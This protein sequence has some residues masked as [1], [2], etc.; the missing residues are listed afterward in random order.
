MAP[1]LR[2]GMQNN[3]GQIKPVVFAA[4][5]RPARQFWCLRKKVKESGVNACNL[6]D[7]SILKKN[8]DF[9]HFL[10]GKWA[11]FWSDCCVGA[12]W[13]AQVGIHPLT[14]AVLL[15]CSTHRPNEDTFK[16]L[17]SQK[18]NRPAGMKRELQGVINSFFFF[19]NRCIAFEE[20]SLHL[21]LFTGS[22]SFLPSWCR[23]SASKASV[24]R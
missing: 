20:R 18:R 1:S 13:V 5:W 7:V 9:S 8:S 4:I 15:P 21:F 17:S 12:S 23:K 14:T 2:T 11:R 24:S 22:I 6:S 19:P 10:V 3:L 16:F